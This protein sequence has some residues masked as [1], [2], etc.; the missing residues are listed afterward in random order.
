MDNA[1]DSFVPQSTGGHVREGHEETDLSVR[2]I[3]TFGVLLAV[4][5]FLSFALMAVF[6]RYLPTMQTAVFGP[7]TPLTAAQ[8][9]L[10]TERAA[11]AVGKVERETEGRPEYYAPETSTIARGEMEEH[12]NKTFPT[13]RLQYDDVR[14]LQTFRMSEQDWLASTFKDNDGNVHISIDRAMDSIAEHGLPQVSGPFV[15]PTLPTAVPMVPA[16]AASHK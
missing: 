3:V 16:P 6:H 5:G 7:P 4:C 2:G 1:R 12:L 14:E 11:P 8:Q 10:Q 13:P 15:A 9:Q